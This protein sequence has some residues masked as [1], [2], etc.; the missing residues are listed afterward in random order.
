MV[1]A[2]NLGEER[3]RKKQIIWGHM[4]FGGAREIWG[5]RELLEGSVRNFPSLMDGV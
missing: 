5:A 4:T 1:L 2:R 3:K